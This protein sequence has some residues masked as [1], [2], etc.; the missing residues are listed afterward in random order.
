[1]AVL[2][3]ASGQSWQ[4]AGGRVM[5]VPGSWPQIPA[6][7]DAAHSLGAGA[8]NVARPT[9]GAEVCQ[10]PTRIDLSYLTDLARGRDHSA[11]RLG[12]LVTAHRVPGRL[13]LARKCHGLY[14]GLPS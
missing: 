2:A 9:G 1:M 12:T 5:S 11:V 3:S 13:Q 4:P 6:G 7:E 8:A 10:V 14:K